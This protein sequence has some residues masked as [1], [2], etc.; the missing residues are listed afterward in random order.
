M[1][2]PFVFGV[3]MIW[4]VFTGRDAHREALL[5]QVQQAWANFARSGGLSEPGLV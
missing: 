3:M 1:E 4:I 2:L 5:N